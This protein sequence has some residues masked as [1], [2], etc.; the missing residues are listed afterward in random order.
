MS[1]FSSQDQKEGANNKRKAEEDRAYK[2]RE[3]KRGKQLTFDT[4]HVAS[5]STTSLFK[6]SSVKS[7]AISFAV[8]YIF[9]IHSQDAEAELLSFII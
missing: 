4:Q 6:T 2:K 7:T 5:H 8:T 1:T 3:R 9:L